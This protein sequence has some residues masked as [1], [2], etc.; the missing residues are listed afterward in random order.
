MTS[1]RKHVQRV[2]E[3]ETIW[4]QGK[5]RKI[6]ARLGPADVVTFRLVGHRR[7]NF[8]DGISL[9]EL[10]WIALKRTVQRRWEEDNKRRKDLG[11]KPRR[12]PTVLRH[13]G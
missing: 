5:N 4:E 10:Y 1:I 2:T 6:V 13:H 7:T 9:K 12:K 11:Q 3:T 8:T